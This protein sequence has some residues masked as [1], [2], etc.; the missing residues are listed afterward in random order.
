ML[1]SF[2]AL[3]LSLNKALPALPSVV[4]VVHHTVGFE[5]KIHHNDNGFINKDQY[6][7]LCRLSLSLSCTLL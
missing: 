4:V 2:D 7:H 1:R 5:P 6:H 3:L